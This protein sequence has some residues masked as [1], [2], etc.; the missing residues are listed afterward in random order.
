MM[1]KY[2]N[3]KTRTPDGIVFD[4]KK[5]AARWTNLKLM[6]K[7]GIITNLQRQVKFELIP[8][9][10]GERACSYKADFVYHDAKTCKMVVEDTKGYRTEAYKIKRKL[11]LYK[12]GIKI[13]EI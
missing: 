10:D 12:Y 6:E 3:Q 11:M 7:A 2:Y 5:E 9:Q 1:S 8:K 4:S 13:T